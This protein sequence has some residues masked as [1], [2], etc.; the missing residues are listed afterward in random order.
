MQWTSLLSP[1]FCVSLLSV[2]LPAPAQNLLPQVF[3]DLH[4]PDQ[5]VRK[6]ANDR[7]VASFGHDLNT[8]EQESNLLCSSL[9]DNDG[10]I[11]QQASGILNVLTLTFSEH[12]QIAQ[13]C[14]TNL[15]AAASDSQPRVRLNALLTL[16]KGKLIPP[17]EAKKAFLDAL[18]DPAE[19]LHGL[20]ALGL[21][22]LPDKS[23]IP[24]VAAALASSEV[25][26]AK[27]HL[28]MAVTLAKTADPTLDNIVQA[29]L[30]DKDAEVQ[31]AAI[32]ATGSASADRS[33]A[34]AALQNL[35]ASDSGTTATRN[36][37]FL[38]AERLSAK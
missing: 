5:N 20:G 24:I 26:E 28:L 13:G 19:D 2:P 21:L 15:V 22:K 17:A 34:V 30:Y 11:R 10:Y 33:R 12:A 37:A 6:A 25:K 9:R 27:L 1:L 4:S 7:I 38:M 29:Q 8:I 32:G 31:E 14:L 35:A 18:N 36:R 23:G 3:T 16:T